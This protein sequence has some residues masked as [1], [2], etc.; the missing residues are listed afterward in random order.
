MSEAVLRLIREPSSSLHDHLFRAVHSVKGMAA[1]MS[2]Q[3]LKE[4]GHAME[5]L[6]EEIHC[7]ALAVDHQTVKMLLGGLDLMETLIGEFELT[8]KS[9]TSYSEFIESIR[10]VA[11][12]AGSRTRQTKAEGKRPNLELIIPER[13]QKYSA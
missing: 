3:P 12:E 9:V 6:F 13:P 7:G 10:L 5:D 4:I 1:S 11:P 8:G 2:F